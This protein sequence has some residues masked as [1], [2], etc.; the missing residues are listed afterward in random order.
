M[1]DAERRIR[2]ARLSQIIREPTDYL[3]F[4]AFT[5]PNAKMWDSRAIVSPRELENFLLILS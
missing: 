5:I 2:E 3:P 4:L 1:S